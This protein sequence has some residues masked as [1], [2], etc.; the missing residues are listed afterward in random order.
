MNTLNTVTS[1]RKVLL[2][3]G[4]GLA[5][6]AGFANAASI[7]GTPTIVVKYD[8]QSL[9]S[10]DNARALYRRL[11]SAARLVCP[12]DSTRDLAHDAAARSCQKESILRAVRQ[13]NN[14]RLAQLLV[15]NVAG[16]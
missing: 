11:E 8:A 1:T 12:S 3:V 13:I 2:A 14:P 7:D 6:T 10:A 4:L 15:N 5:L 9:D 16:G